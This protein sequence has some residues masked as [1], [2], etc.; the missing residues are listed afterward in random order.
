MA[1]TQE[2]IEKIKTESS[3]KK[4]IELNIF[5]KFFE[6]LNKKYLKIDYCSTIT[7]TLDIA[8]EFYKYYNIHYYET[9]TKYMQNNHIIIGRYLDKSYVDT[10]NG[11]SY[12]HLTGNDSDLFILVHEFAHFIDR[13]IKPHIIPNEFWFLSEVFSFYIE[14]KLERWLDNEY[15]QLI[16]A[17]RENRLYFESKMIEAIKYQLKYEKIYLE[18]GI[19]TKED[20]IPKEMQLIKQYDYPNLVNYLIMYPIANVLSEYLL[21]YYSELSDKDLCQI[22]LDTNLYDAIEM[23]QNYE[24]KKN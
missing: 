24:L 13:N 10:N 11:K 14:K 8:L 2:N 18:K 22:C 20:I 9:I 7:N 5:D 17:R 15:E 21:N 3:Y 19:I 12:I 1:I 6:M 4:I 23:F 16:F